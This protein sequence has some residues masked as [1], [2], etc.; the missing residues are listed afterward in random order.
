MAD[1]VFLQTAAA[2]LA[3]ASAAPPTPNLT[4]YPISHLLPDGLPR[5]RITAVAGPPKTGKSLLAHHAIVSF[6]L[7][8]SNG[9]DL[10][11]VIDPGELKREFSTETLVKV[12]QVRLKEDPHGYGAREGGDG[13]VRECLDR[14]LVMKTYDYEGTIE[15]LGELAQR[16]EATGHRPPPESPA[17][18]CITTTPAAATRPRKR[19]MIIQDSDPENSSSNDEDDDDDDDQPSPP[20][21]STPEPA[22]PPRVSLLVLESISQTIHPR[23]STAHPITSQ[24]NLATLLR[25]LRTLTVTHNLTT[26]LLNAALDP[27]F[28]KPRSGPYPQTPL[29]PPAPL[30]LAL[31]PSIFSAVRCRPALGRALAHGLDLELMLARLPKRRLDVQKREMGW[32]EEDV[33][34]VG[35]LEVLGDRHG[36]VGAERWVSFEIRGMGCW[37]V[38]W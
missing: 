7:D 29:P 30:D 10:V 5:G 38:E 6:L 3:H 17:R 8:P 25:T 13:K 34:M 31:H 26:L 33:E 32:A 4:F 21:I 27:P 28:P 35:V 23:L 12:L 2:M 18:A 22:S 11:A 14:V 20:T 24:S 9:N 15:A 19:R 1:H 36:V 37:A 16:L